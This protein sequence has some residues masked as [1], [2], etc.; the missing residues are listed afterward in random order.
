MKTMLF[1]AFEKNTVL[2]TC[3]CNY[4]TQFEFSLN[5]TVP[6][7]YQSELVRFP[8]LQQVNQSMLQGISRKVYIRSVGVYWILKVD[9][10]V[11]ISSP[12]DSNLNQFNPY[13]AFRFYFPSPV[14]IYNTKLLTSVC[15]SHN[16]IVNT[17][18]VFAKA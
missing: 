18:E 6:S 7:H 2:K 14:P 9:Y 1:S 17:C 5:R 10:R 8:V 3:T 13:L 15:S 4:I 12:L 11:Y 16:Q